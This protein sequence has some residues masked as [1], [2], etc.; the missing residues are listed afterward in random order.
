MTI[1]GRKAKQATITPRLFQ[2]QNRVLFFSDAG[3]MWLAFFQ[4]WEPMM[5]QARSSTIRM[6]RHHSVGIKVMF[7]FP[8][9]TRTARISNTKARTHSTIAPTRR[10]V[11]LP[12]SADWPCSA[13]SLASA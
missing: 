11:A 6:I 5:T 1:S 7:S 13:A 9:M 10:P 3:R 2:S 4:S 12:C 8:K